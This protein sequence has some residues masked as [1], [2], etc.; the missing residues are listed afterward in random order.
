MGKSA[1]SWVARIGGYAAAPFTGGAS[2][3]VG[4]AVAEG[5]SHSAAND[6]ANEQLQAGNNQ[7]IDLYKQ[8]YAPYLNA[9]SQASSTLA[10]LMGF[11]P[12]P[13]GQATPAAAPAPVAAAEPVEAPKP[14]QGQSG[15]HGYGM[16]GGLDTLQSL[17]A[18]QP[19]Q[20][21]YRTVRMRAPDGT[22]EDVPH[23]QARHFLD[24]GAELVS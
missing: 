15:G 18:R 9:G 6:K 12:S 24:L 21:S 3:P 1:W 14:Y 17:A 13:T 11:S 2:I 10:G 7:A 22:E 8:T 5:L 16:T 4:E 19:T 20:S 23:A